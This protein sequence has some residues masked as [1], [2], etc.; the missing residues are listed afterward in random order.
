MT[1]P[2]GTTRFITGNN[3]QLGFAVTCPN[4]LNFGAGGMGTSVT[5]AEE[6][7]D[8]SKGPDEQEAAG[9]WTDGGG[10]IMAH[11]GNYQVKITALDPRCRWSVAVYPAN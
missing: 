4:D 11:G 2:S 8:G 1:V 9:P 10:G 3:W 7:V 5:F 6:L